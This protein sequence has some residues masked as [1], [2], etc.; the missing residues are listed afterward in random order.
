M[1]HHSQEAPAFRT[2]GEDQ[3]FLLPYSVMSVAFDVVRV[4]VE[5]GEKVVEEEN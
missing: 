4:F 3:L 1:L 5:I 2:F